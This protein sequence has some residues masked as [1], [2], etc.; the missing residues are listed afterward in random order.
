[1]PWLL[2]FRTDKFTWLF[3][4]FF[5]FQ[6]FV[7]MLLMNLSNTK[8]LTNTL[9]LKNQTKNKIWLKM[10]HFSSIWGK[11]PTHF[12]SVQTSLTGKCSCGNH[13]H[14]N[15]RHPTLSTWV[16]SIIIKSAEGSCTHTHTCARCIFEWNNIT[17]KDILSQRYLSQNNFLLNQGPFCGVTG[18][19]CFGFRVTT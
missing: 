11:I 1:M 4:S 6:Y 2:Y 15:I 13:E 10:L 5:H 16:K 7:R 3:Q 8:I 14:T 12:Q 18:T 17:T 19:P 9:P